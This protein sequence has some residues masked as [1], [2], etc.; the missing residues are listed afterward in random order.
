MTAWLIGQTGLNALRIRDSKLAYHY[1]NHSTSFVIGAAPKG[2]NTTPVRLY[3]SY[4]ELTGPM[5]PYKYVIYNPEYYGED[6]TKT[7]LIE[8]QH[9]TAFLDAFATLAHR[10]G[11]KVIAAP[12]RDLMAQ[13]TADYSS[14]T[15]NEDADTAFL[16]ARIPAACAT[17]DI[18]HLQNQAN[19]D[20]LVTFRALIDGSSAQLPTGFPMWCGLTTL[21]SDTVAEMVAAYH[22]ALPRCTGF[23]LNTNTATI[24]LAEAFLEAIV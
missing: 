16:N 21:R 4:T 19:Q 6:Y 23:W 9:P 17:S 24:A 7:P 10:H 14:A 11:K 5:T 2:W 12:A 20:D 13:K 18:F 1:F 15:H 8:Q 3:E 22:A